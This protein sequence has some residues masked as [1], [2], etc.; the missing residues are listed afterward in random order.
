MDC[1]MNDEFTYEVKV[2]QVKQSKR[3]SVQRI[4]AN[5]PPIRYRFL[6]LGADLSQTPANAA[7]PRIQANH[8][9]VICHAMCLFTPQAFACIH[10]TYPR[11]DSLG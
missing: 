3:G 5:T 4:I 2:Q 6:Y 9:H 11:R 10:C 8:S 1:L 7:N